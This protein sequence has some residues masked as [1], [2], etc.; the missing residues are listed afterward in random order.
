[1]PFDD[2]KFILFC[3]KGGVGKTTCATATAVK[4][5]RA[6]YKTLLFSTDPA[7]SIADCL[8]Q[9]VTNKINE[10]ANLPN[11]FASEID[12]GIELKTFTKQYERE[13]NDFLKKTTNLDTEDINDFMLLTLP[14]IDELMAIKK[15]TDFIENKN[16]FSYFVCDTAPTGHTLRLISMPDVANDWIKVLASIQWKYKDIM[17][18]FSNNIVED[19]DFLLILKRIVNKVRSV[20]KEPSQTIFNIVTIPEALSVME[21][22]RLIAALNNLGIIAKNLIINNIIPENRNCTF[23]TKYREMQN[24]YI[25]ELN[26]SLTNIK[27]ISKF[28]NISEVKGIKNLEDFSQDLI[29]SG[30]T[31]YE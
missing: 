2:K 7:H 6:G 19:N 9:P 1:M 16:D 15:I 20:L 3:G 10:I 27:I 4:L 23:C 24:T 5:S 12:A 14:G 21:T 26:D 13:M 31:D 11:L 22:K 18:R 29:L 30:V 8:E 17:S 25:K 28:K